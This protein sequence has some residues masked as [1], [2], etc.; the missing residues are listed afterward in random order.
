M[1]YTF[2]KS[3]KVEPGSDVKMKALGYPDD[4]KIDDNKGGNLYHKSLVDPNDN[5]GSDY[6]VDIEAKSTVFK[7]P[8]NVNV[9]RLTITS[10][11]HWTRKDGEDKRGS[12]ISRWRVDYVKRTGFDLNFRIVL[13]YPTF[14]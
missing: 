11:T 1:P 10:Q 3:L 12:S 8:N 5:H 14:K 7:V 13:P 9:I 2:D 6:V 4:F